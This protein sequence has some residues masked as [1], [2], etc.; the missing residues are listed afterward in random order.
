VAHSS[1]SKTSICQ[2]PRE[3]QRDLHSFPCLH[4]AAVPTRPL[5]ERDPSVYHIQT[6]A[7]ILA[8]SSLAQ[9]CAALL[10]AAVSSSIVILT[11]GSSPRAGELMPSIVRPYSCSFLTTLHIGAP[12]EGLLCSSFSLLLHAFSIHAANC[13]CLESKVTGAGIS[14][15]SLIRAPR[16]VVGSASRMDLAC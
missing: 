11:A 16:R 8:S 9:R 7:P 15:D 10:E 2:V 12:E 14:P 3:L 5:S 6:P 13:C 4:T 1:A